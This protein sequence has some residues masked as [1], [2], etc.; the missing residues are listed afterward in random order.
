MTFHWSEE[1]EN[2]VSIL[3]NSLFSIASISTPDIYNPFEIHRDASLTGIRGCLRQRDSH[4]K[5][6]T[7]VFTIQ[8]LTSIQS[9]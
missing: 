8:K 1:T 2:S 9:K 4:G 3:K 5:I 7:I 6:K